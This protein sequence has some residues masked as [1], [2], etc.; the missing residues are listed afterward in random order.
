MYLESI[1]AFNEELSYNFVPVSLIFFSISVITKKSKTLLTMTSWHDI[2]WPSCQRTCDLIFEF[3]FCTHVPEYMYICV[4]YRFETSNN[5]ISKNMMLWIQKMSCLCFR[6][7]SC[8]IMCVKSLLK[9][10]RYHN[11]YKDVFREVGLLEVMV[12]CLH[13]YAALLKEPHEEGHGQ[14]YIP[15]Y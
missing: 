1:L 2:T 11:V 4:M 6:S 3:N 10:L 12:T 14:Y 15:R 8:S 13:R 9:V 5:F 7:M